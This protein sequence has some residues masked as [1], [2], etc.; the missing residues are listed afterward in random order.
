MAGF[1]EA[2]RNTKSLPSL[3]ESGAQGS[4]NWINTLFNTWQVSG[5]NALSI[6]SEKQCYCK[7]KLYLLAS[8]SLIIF[9]S[10]VEF[11]VPLFKFP[12][13]GETVQVA[14]TAVTL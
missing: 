4:G 1:H 13:Q 5:G 3:Q 14:A 12:I 10:T 8:Y 7:V 2:F 11:S 6:D 9:I